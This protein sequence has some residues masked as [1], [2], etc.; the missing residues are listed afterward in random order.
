M[1]DEIREQPEV[2]NRLLESEHSS[3]SKLK[4]AMVE[5]GIENIVIAG[6]GTSDNAATYAKYLFQI[7][8]GRMVALAAPSVFTLYE[9]DMDLSKWLMIGISQSGESTDV[10]EILRQ[11]DAHGALTAGITNVVDS[12]MSKVADHTLYCRAGDER[13]VAATKT[14][15]AT[16]G[17]IYLLSCCLKND[18]SMLDDLKCAIQAIRGVLAQEEHIS[19]IVERYR[20]MNEC[21]VVARGYNQSTCQEVSLKLNETCYVVAKPYSAADIQHGPVAMIDEGF[22]V[23]VFAPQGKGFQSVLDLAVKLN[24]AGAELIVV[25]DDDKILDLGKTQIKIEAV[26]EAVSPMVNIV[27]GQLFAQYLSLAKGNNPDKPRHLKKVTLTM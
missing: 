5:R 26:P 15:S 21:M 17:L 2:L 20:Y 27:V 11:S 24:S 4:D 25:S 3:V 12:T 14:Y 23:I 22:P 6:R 7:V 16:L 19:R 8:N 13:S 10:V 18:N 9:S 1:L